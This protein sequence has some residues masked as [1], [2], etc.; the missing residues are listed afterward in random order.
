MSVWW[1]SLGSNFSSRSSN[2][3]LLLRDFCK[4]Q[5]TYSS[6]RNHFLTLHI[7]LTLPLYPVESCKRWKFGLEK[8]FIIFTEASLQN[9]FNSKQIVHIFMTTV[10][11]LKTWRAIS[12]KSQND[13]IGFIWQYLWF[14]QCHVLYV[15]QLYWHVPTSFE[16]SQCGLWNC[17]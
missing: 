5:W 1:P 16:V 3:S 14:S 17:P 11:W 6:L 2:P 7:M 13:Y 10:T 8:F 15:I 12:I 4:K 9:D